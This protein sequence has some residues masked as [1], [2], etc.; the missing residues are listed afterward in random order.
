VH[1][2]V[3]F[4]VDLSASHVN[5]IEDSY[6]LALRVSPRLAPGLIAKPLMPIAFGL[7]ASPGYIADHSV[8]GSIDE[9]F[10]HP[11]L[12][13][14]GGPKLEEQLKV[15]RRGRSKARAKSLITSEN[16]ILLLHACKAGMGL[17]VLPDWLS[18]SE[19]LNGSLQRL[20]ADN[21]D[22]C[23][24]VH[25]VYSNRRQMPA[26]VRKFLNFLGPESGEL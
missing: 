13:Y 20:L 24:R 8:P 3:T 25:A 9:I 22:V 19:V 5:L 7:Y 12:V 2:D 4:D 11:M 17:V 6:D 23:V 10:E 21:F 26:R 14:S 16:E 1:P 18:E 15:N